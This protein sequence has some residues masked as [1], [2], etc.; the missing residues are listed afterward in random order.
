MRRRQRGITLVVVTIALFSLL[1][2]GGLALDIGRVMVDKSR[3]QATVDAAALSAAKVLDVT[4]STTQAT[5]AATN[6]FTLNAQNHADLWSMIGSVTRTVEYS[7]T[8]VPFAAGTTPP[9]YVRVTASGFSISATLASVAGINNFTIA[10]KAVAGPS[11]TINKAC[12]IAPMLMC[13]TPLPAGTPPSDTNFYGYTKGEITVLKYAGGGGGSGV[14]PGNYMLLDEG[15]G[16]SAVRQALAGSYASCATINKTVTTETGVA[17]GPV[18]QGLNTRFNEYQGP[19]GGTQSTYPPDVVTNQPTSKTSRLSCGDKSC[20][21]VVTGSPSQIVTDSSG[22]SSWSYEGMYQPAL[23][24]GNYDVPPPT[25]VPDR[26]ILAVPIGDCT[27]AGTGKSNVTVLG[28]ACVFM[29]QDVDQSDSNVF[30]EVLGK[31][32]V[33]GN[34]GPAPASGPGPYIIQLY[35]VDGSPES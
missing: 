7:N 21:T 18:A 8:L 22:Y 3:L 13:G 29:L 6:V 16:G 14:G 33:N 31:C 30:G 11:P 26:R 24:H 25:G 4:G 10:A 5:T 12:N 19:L 1:V 17:A 27:T 34:P 2:V 28:L 32:Q 15:S 20:T 23:Q 9:L 35:H